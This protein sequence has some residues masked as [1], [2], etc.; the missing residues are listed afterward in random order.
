M[1]VCDA[2]FVVLA[3]WLGYTDL[4]LHLQSARAATDMLCYKT[5][6]FCF[7]HL[8]VHLY[9]DSQGLLSQCSRFAKHCN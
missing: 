6:L 5:P 2:L 1:V 7:G 9:K 3:L 8:S 4:C